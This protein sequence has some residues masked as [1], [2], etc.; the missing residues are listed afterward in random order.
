MLRV[1]RLEI[2]LPA[3]HRHPPSVG[4]AHGTRGSPVRLHHLLERRG[5]LAGRLH[6]RGPKP[7][8]AAEGGVRPTRNGGVGDEN[9]RA[10]S[11]S[12][13]QQNFRYENG[14][15][16][17]GGSLVVAEK[18]FAPDVQHRSL[19]H[20]GLHTHTL[21]PQSCGELLLTRPPTRRRRRRRH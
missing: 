11:D 16:R 2:S 10:A 9:C 19:E 5:R 14:E 21:W 18:P 6:N 20:R 4:P 13:A 12:R 7:E 1:Q 17:R 3:V 15:R 8:V